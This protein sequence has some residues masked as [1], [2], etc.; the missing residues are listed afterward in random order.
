MNMLY[1]EYMSVWVGFIAI[2][3]MVTLISMRVRFS[4]RAIMTILVIL[5]VSCSLISAFRPMESLD[6]EQYAKT[7]S[8]SLEIVE[9]T[10]LWD[11]GAFFANR[12]N[13]SIEFGFILFMALFRLFNIPLGVF[14]F[15]NSFVSNALIIY[16]MHLLYEF[17]ANAKDSDSKRVDDRCTHL[18]LMFCFFM[19][20]SGILFSSIAIRAAL[21]LGLVLFGI[22]NLLLGKR[23]VLACIA[24][25]FAVAVHTT[26][27]V[28]IVIFL[29]IKFGKALPSLN[30]L[31]L[32]FV[33]AALGYF[34]NV[35]QVT[36]EP[37]VTLI[38]WLL[39]VLRIDAFSSYL[40]NL[41]YVVQ[42]REGFLLVVW[43]LCM[44]LGYT[45][46]ENAGKM[47]VVTLIGLFMYT[48]A[49]PIHALSRL[50]EFFVVVSIPA[51][52]YGYEQEA[53]YSRFLP[54]VVLLLFI[55]QYVM[56]F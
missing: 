2:V 11:F 25:V 36:L 21:A 30:M 13:D 42:M 37:L 46:N 22:A 35:S 7:F 19:L 14:F 45:K 52:V 43:G 6:T 40:T 28:F 4:K 38:H 3:C 44:I 55:P 15:I 33:V 24:L 41:T 1:S 49:Y 12:S 51:C 47:F 18:I 16:S 50:V 9:E 32:L 29:V 31:V 34:L 27:L 53:P 23:R 5:I 20:S 8:L 17:I 26:A 54:F 48:F 10:P 56:V 39:G